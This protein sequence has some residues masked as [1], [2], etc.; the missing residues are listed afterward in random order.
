MVKRIKKPSAC[1]PPSYLGATAASFII[2]RSMVRNFLRSEK[3]Q[4]LTLLLS[5]SNGLILTV[6]GLARWSK[7]M[8]DSCSSLR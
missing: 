1:R 4:S 3:T 5:R 8:K 2:T 6:V 7:N